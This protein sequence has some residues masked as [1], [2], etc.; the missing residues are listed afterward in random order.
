MSYEPIP[1]VLIQILGGGGYHG[2]LGVYLSDV[3]Y[4]RIIPQSTPFAVPAW[5]GTRKIDLEDTAVEAVY[6]KEAHYKEARLCRELKNMEKALQRRIQNTL[7]LKYIEPLLNK[8]MGLIKDD[9]PTVLQ[10]LD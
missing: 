9:L 4:A 6:A 2:Y 3:D 10:Y 7:E 8:N 1:L 5:L